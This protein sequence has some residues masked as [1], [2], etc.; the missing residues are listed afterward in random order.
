MS[1]EPL[2]LVLEFGRR[3]EKTDDGCLSIG[4]CAHAGHADFYANFMKHERVFHRFISY[5]T[6]G[7]GDIIEPRMD[8]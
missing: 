1:L 4:L 3:K 7:I 2:L 8:N 6:K 5:F